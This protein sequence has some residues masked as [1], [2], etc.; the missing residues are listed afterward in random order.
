MKVT[1]SGCPSKTALKKASTSG[2]SR[3]RYRHTARLADDNVVA[4]IDDAA[5]GGT[6]ALLLYNLF[7]FLNYI[8]IYII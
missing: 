8:M 7:K 2:V 3:T 6:V 5:S 4:P 1:T